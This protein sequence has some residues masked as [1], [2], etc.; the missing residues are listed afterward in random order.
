MGL[1]YDI[2]LI[3]FPSLSYLIEQNDIQ[4]KKYVNNAV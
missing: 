1:A 2:T 4:V 3:I